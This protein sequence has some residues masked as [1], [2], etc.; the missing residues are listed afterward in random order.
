MCFVQALSA[1]TAP[2]MGASAS[3][4]PRAQQQ[5]RMTLPPSFA[6]AFQTAL[7][8]RLAAVDISLAGLGS[9]NA[10]GMAADAGR[11]LAAASAGATAAPLRPG[12]PALCT[13]AERCLA[14]AAMESAVDLPGADAASDAERLAAAAALTA[15]TRDALLAALQ[16]GADAGASGGGMPAALLAR[17]L[18]ALAQ[19][20]SQPSPALLQALASRE[21]LWWSPAAGDA[22][23]FLPAAS[24]SGGA[25]ASSSASGSSAPGRPVACRDAAPLLSALAA[26]G[27]R[28]DDR[29]RRRAADWAARSDAASSAHVAEVAAVLRGLAALSVRPPADWLASVTAAVQEQLPDA[30]FDDVSS[31]LWAFDAW[32]YAPPADVAAD[33]AAVLKA[34]A[35]EEQPAGRSVFE[36]MRL[37]NRLLHGRS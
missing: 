19:L 8:A 1:L 37:L 5:Q 35:A 27:F 22:A 10:A 14:A 15:A 9:S 11:L 26:S 20:G 31:L 18:A 29:W 6:A 34:A 25:G 36:S 16:Q 17:A 30:S 32:Q 28:P 24:T 3:D 2:Q 4:L 13:L 33:L 21:D 7:T 12:L 23:A